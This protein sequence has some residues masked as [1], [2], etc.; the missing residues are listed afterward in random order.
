[1]RAAGARLCPG[2][3]SCGASGRAGNAASAPGPPAALPGRR[4]PP[5]PP[6]RRPR[7]ER[8]LQEQAQQALA[9]CTFTPRINDK[10]F[11][12][13]AYR[14]IHERLGEVLRQRHER[15]MR[16]KLRAEQEDVDASFRPRLNSRSLQM[17]E[18]AR[19]GAKGW[20]LVLVP[21]ALDPGLAAA[22]RCH[23]GGGGPQQAAGS[24]LATS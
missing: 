7:R 22:A 24:K 8:K 17:A 4:Q 11:E 10:S 9:E 1:L 14:P 20:G 13:Q 21:P 15:M 3:R 18:R 12:L 2:Q 5:P 23:A 16:S 19:W 6:C